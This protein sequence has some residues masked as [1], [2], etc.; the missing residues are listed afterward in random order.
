[1]VFKIISFIFIVLLFVI[2]ETAISPASAENPSEKMTKDAER[3][4]RRDKMIA[5]CKVEYAAKVAAKKAEAPAK[6]AEKKTEV[7]EVI[8]EKK[9]EATEVADKI[10]T[11]TE[12]ITTEKTS[13]VEDI[14][15]TVESALE[16]G[17]AEAGS[18]V[19]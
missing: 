8:A 15:E 13:D 18:K 4:A 5:E 9:V 12:S 10:I 6:V 14:A 1:M 17:A 2:M 16:H 3:I 11:E 7:T 19:D